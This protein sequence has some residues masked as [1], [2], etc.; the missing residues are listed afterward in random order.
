MHK[1]SLHHQCSIAEKSVVQKPN[2][3][4]WKNV[5]KSTKEIRKG[6]EKTNM[7]FAISFALDFLVLFCQ[8]KRTE[9]LLKLSL[10]NPA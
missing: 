5:L 8:E 3:G 6:N 2:Q 1:V 9:E 4:E 7:C 10:S